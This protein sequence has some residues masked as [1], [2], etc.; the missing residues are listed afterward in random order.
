MRYAVALKKSTYSLVKGMISFDQ[1]GQGGGGKG[2]GRKM[3]LPISPWSACFLMWYDTH[4][5]FSEIFLETRKTPKKL[6][7]R[8]SAGP[9]KSDLQ[10]EE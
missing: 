9:P 2:S 3:V 5:G 10:V 1:G 4:K 6:A 8:S 7:G